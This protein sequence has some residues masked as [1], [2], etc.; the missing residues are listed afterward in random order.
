M[1]FTGN[2]KNGN[3]LVQIIGMGNLFGIN[4]L[5]YALSSVCCYWSV[6][7]YRGMWH[8]AGACSGHTH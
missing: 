6:S 2:P 1:Y 4:G 8:V 7:L 3:G 5:N